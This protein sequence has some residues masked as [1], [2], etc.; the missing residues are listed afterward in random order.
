[1]SAPSDAKSFAIPPNNP[2][3]ESP[4]AM[5]EFLEDADLVWMFPHMHVRAK[6]MIYR[7]GTPTGLVRRPSSPA[8]SP[9]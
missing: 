4:P 5:A 8:S 2:D 9:A 1:M 3:W 6:D 7:L